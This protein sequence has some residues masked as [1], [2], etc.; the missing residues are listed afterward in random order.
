VYD[1]T[2]PPRSTRLARL[3]GVTN[4]RIWLAF[5]TGIVINALALWIANGI[6]GGVVIE[7]FWAYFFGALVLGIA[8][9]I[10]KPILAILTLPLIL[11]TLG[12]FYLLI[13]IGMIALTAWIVPDFSVSGFWTYVGVVV[14]VWIVNW[15]ANAFIER[16]AASFAR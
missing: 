1:G 16:S 7:G 10:I 4:G 8:N 14:I 5:L 13:N 6:F 9:A 12:F 11:V 3:A 2:A 15:A